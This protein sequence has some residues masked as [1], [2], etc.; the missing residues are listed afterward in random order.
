MLAALGYRF[1]DS[2]GAEL[3]PT[4]ENL[5][6]VHSVD[7]RHAVELDRVEMIVA[8]DVTS[9]LLGPT[10]AAAIFAPQKGAS[11]TQVA[12]LGGGLENFVSAFTRSNY[13]SA[14]TLA[15]ASGS[16]AA[17]GIGYA[18]MLL[19]ATMAS[20]ADYFLD[21]LNF[22][23][24]ATDVDLVITGEGRL[25]EQTLRGKLPV[26]VALRAAPKPV[27]AV[28]GRNDLGADAVG[29]PFSDVITVAELADTDTSRDPHRTAQLLQHIGTRIG[30]KLGTS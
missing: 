12:Q 24:V 4:A 5:A 30:R 11:A 13:A 10:G 22:D 6:V 29:T 25:D 28:V 14:G 18:A 27:I 17:G 2:T 7:A 15:H 16:G 1:L 20:G 26:A 3:A 19:G 23:R 8:S 9:P 21:L